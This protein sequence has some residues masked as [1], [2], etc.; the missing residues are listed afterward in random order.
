MS[1]LDPLSKS[2]LNAALLGGAAI[3]GF[4]VWS[5]FRSIVQ[6][7]LTPDPWDGQVSETLEN[8]DCL[9]VC[10]SCL[11]QHDSSVHFCPQCGVSVGA[12]TSLIPPLYLSSIGDV[13]RAG[14][15]GTYRRS[16]FLTV[17][18]FF[19][20]FVAYGLVAPLFFLLPIYWLRL[21]RRIFG[22]KDSF[23]APTQP[24]VDSPLPPA[25]PD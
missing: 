3:V 1:L 5:T 20:A 21:L 24:P 12:Y 18:Y 23:E 6:R 15:E 8:D 14:T 10:H 9:E 11:S 19:A 16:P 17:S 13:F 4:A 22:P 25:L 2:E 7:P